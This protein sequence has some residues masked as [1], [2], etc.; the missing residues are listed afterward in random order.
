MCEGIKNPPKPGPQK[1][2]TIHTNREK[3]SRSPLAEDPVYQQGPTRALISQMTV[4]LATVSFFHHTKQ[5]KKTTSAVTYY[6][7]H[8]WVHAILDT[9]EFWNKLFLVHKKRATSFYYSTTLVII[10][11]EKKISKCWHQK[12]KR[13]NHMIKMSCIKYQYW[14]IGTRAFVYLYMYI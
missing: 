11:T 7:L 9:K 13:D 14:Q 8:K 10:A 6:K 1:I 4:V 5:N 2:K 3:M 12:W